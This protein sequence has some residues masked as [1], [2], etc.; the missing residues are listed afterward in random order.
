MIDD[1]ETEK[2]FQTKT[3]GVLLLLLV[4]EKEK[5]NARPGGRVDGQEVTGCTTKVW[6][7]FGN[8]LGTQ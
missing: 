2:I 8:M 1:I 6:L 7:T 5:Q 3:A 4:L